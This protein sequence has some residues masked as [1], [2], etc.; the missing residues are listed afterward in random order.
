MLFDG[1]ANAW[2]AALPTATAIAVA[3]V[4]WRNAAA[5]MSMPSAFL[6]VHLLLHLPRELEKKKLWKY[7]DQ[8]LNVL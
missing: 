6:L 8:S 4:G 2:D 3:A 7:K 1:C 5:I